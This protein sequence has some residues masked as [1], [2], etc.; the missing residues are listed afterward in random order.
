MHQTLVQKRSDFSVVGHTHIERPQMCG[1]NCRFP[2][3]PPSQLEDPSL[4]P[5]PFPPHPPLPL[6]PTPPALRAQRLKNYFN[7]A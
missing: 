5:Q 3:N 7:L 6:P 2:S 1:L 4:K